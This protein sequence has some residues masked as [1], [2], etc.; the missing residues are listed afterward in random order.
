VVSGLTV[1][2]CSVLYCS[3][4]GGADDSHGNQ[5]QLESAFNDANATWEISRYSGVQ[6][7]FTI[8]DGSAYNLNADARSWESMATAF[9]D[10]TIMP[11]KSRAMTNPLPVPC[12][13]LAGRR[14][15]VPLPLCC[16]CNN[17]SDSILI[18]LWQYS[19]CDVTVSRG[20]RRLVHILIKLSSSLF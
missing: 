17:L 6:H 16:S 12:L 2:V 8:W 11:E 7:G 20:S 14:S 15:P 13:C 5:T 3:L 18:Y 4:S 10:K 19:S 9:N 1:F